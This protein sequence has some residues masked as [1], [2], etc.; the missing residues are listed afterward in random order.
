MRVL[1]TA[2]TVG[3]VWTS[4]LEL[5]RGLERHGVHVVLAAMGA[6]LRDDQRAEAEALQ[7]LTLHARPY[8]LEWMERPWRDVEAGSEWLLRLERESAPDVIHLNEFT[9]GSLPWRAPT[10]VVGHSCVLSWW[11][12]VRGE[13]APVRWA[14]Y[15]GAV[16]TGIA[17]ADLVV[18][19][20]RWMAQQLQTHYGPLHRVSVIP[21][22]RDPTGFDPAPKERFIFAAGRAGDEAKNLAALGRAARGLPWSVF[23]AGN[24]EHPDGGRTELGAAHALGRLTPRAVA[25]WYASAAIYAL[26]ARYEPF[27][28]SALEAALSGCALV[29]GDIPS[30]REVWE[31][32]AVFVPPDDELALRDTLLELIRDERRRARIAAAAARRAFRFNASRMARRYARLYT[33]LVG[34]RTPVMAA[35]D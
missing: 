18:A 1:M 2:D 5:T 8:R 22:G 3:G 7:N 9:R 25:R 26:P 34:R 24:T 27:G 13:P 19:P 17:A 21:N 35:G 31:D 30:L 12:A 28:L 16:R 4:A 6:P 11:Q 33:Q 10:V 14:R 32:T 15:A 20:T 29:L 23:I